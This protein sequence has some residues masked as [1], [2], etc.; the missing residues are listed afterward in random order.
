VSI[1]WITP[2]VVKTSALMTLALLTMSA[3]ID[4]DFHVLAFEVFTEDS[5]ITCAAVKSPGTT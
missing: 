5:F 2:L 1:T 3:V 4:G